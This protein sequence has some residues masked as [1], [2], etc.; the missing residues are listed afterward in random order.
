MILKELLPIAYAGL[1]KSTIDKKDIEYYLKIIERRANGNN[2]AT[3][4]IKNYRKLKQ[5]MKRDDAL[6]S[7]TKTLYKN[8][9]TQLPVSDWPMIEEKLNLRTNALLAEQLMST[10][11][12]TVNENDLAA[13]ASSIMTWK[14]IHHVPVLNDQQ[15]LCGLL[16]WSHITEHLRENTASSELK[17]RDL[18]VK[19]VI[20]ITPDTQMETVFRKLEEKRI[21]CLPVLKEGNLVGIITRNDMSTV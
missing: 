1:E 21:G 7:L 17:V 5:Q 12:F 18:M 11:L 4:M 16:T 3:W 14:N 2:G 20:T 15:Q 6:I 13:M 8:Q 19:D 10:H 9:H